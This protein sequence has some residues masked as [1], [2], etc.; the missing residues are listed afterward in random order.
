MIVDS[1]KFNFRVISNDKFHKWPCKLYNMTPIKRYSSLNHDQ[2]RSPDSKSIRLP[3]Q[4]NELS[5]NQLH[6]RSDSLIPSHNESKTSRNRITRPTIINKLARSKLR[7]GGDKIFSSSPSNLD[8]LPRKRKT[9]EINLDVLDT[10][11]KKRY[12]YDATVPPNLNQNE[13]YADDTDS[14]S[15]TKLIDFDRFSSSPVKSQEH[16]PDNDVKKLDELIANKSSKYKDYIKSTL[17]GVNEA[18]KSHGDFASEMVNGN[19]LLTLE[20]HNQA[21]IQTVKE[22]FKDRQYPTPTRSKKSLMERTS[23]HLNIIPQILKGKIETSFFYDLAK[24]QFQSSSH[25]T[26]SQKE[27]WNIDWHKFFAGYYG[28]KRQLF[29]ASLIISK[30][31]RDLHIAANKNKTVSYWTINGFSTFVL[32][33]EIIL[34][35]TMEDLDCDMS[36]AER[37]IQESSEYGTV[38]SDSTDLIDDLNIGELLGSES[39]E[40]MKGIPLV[41]SYEQ[42]KSDEDKS[43]DNDDKTEESPNTE[44]SKNSNIDILDQF[45][46]SSSG[47]DEE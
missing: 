27:K 43:I 30:F 14:D 21:K 17:Q 41:A 20:N 31:K 28:F 3:K 38:V 34:K 16:V 26:M 44:N 47:D 19:I 42:S 5:V 22:K 45:L 32:A 4:E 40:F 18:S 46:D 25:E 7:I 39:K 2:N 12:Q 1:C 10:F 24:N 33:N 29:V 6:D 37:I 11:N 23:K 8:S 35:F 36:K 13:S 15:E 9:E